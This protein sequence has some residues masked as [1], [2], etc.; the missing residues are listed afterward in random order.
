MMPRFA[1]DYEH[2]LKSR[3]CR[4]VMLDGAAYAAMRYAQYTARY[5]RHCRHY[6][7]CHYATTMRALL[8]L[9][10]FSPDAMSAP[11]RR[12]AATRQR[13]MMPDAKAMPALAVTSHIFFR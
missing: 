2:A 8:R 3:I 5:E 6:G 9:R 4:H 11:R 1:A 10:C 7:C 13:T 12:R